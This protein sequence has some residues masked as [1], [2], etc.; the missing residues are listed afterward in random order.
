MPVL[1]LHITVMFSNAPDNLG[2][3]FLGAMFD[4]PLYSPHTSTTY[5]TMNNIKGEKEDRRSSKRC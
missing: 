3:K 5:D 2:Y 4:S 1:P